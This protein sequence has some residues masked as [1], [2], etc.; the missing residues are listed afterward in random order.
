MI[1]EIADLVLQ[2]ASA[3][4]IREKSDSIGVETLFKDGMRK[5]EQGVTTEE[6]V[7]RVTAV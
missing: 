7:R 5:A 4:A 2:K 1:P 6:E 3:H